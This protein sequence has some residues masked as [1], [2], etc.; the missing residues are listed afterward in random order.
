MAKYAESIVYNNNDSTFMMI[1][2]LRRWIEMK[3]LKKETFITVGVLVALAIAT[4]AET[5][6]LVS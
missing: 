3:V 5:P 6:W 2:S 1:A 4:V